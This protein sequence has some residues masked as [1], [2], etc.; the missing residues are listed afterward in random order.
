V[1]TIDHRG[2]LGDHALAIRGGHL[3]GGE[4]HVAAEAQA[5]LGHRLA[6]HRAD[7]TRER[8]ADGVRGRRVQFVAVEAADVVGLE[9]LGVG[10]LGHA[11]GMMPDNPPP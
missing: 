7:H 8:T 4:A 2:A 3:L 11:Q 1:P 6:L 10:E 5:Q 9:H